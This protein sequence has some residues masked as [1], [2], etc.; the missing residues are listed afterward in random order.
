MAKNDLAAFYKNLRTLGIHLHGKTNTSME[1]NSMDDI[2][3]SLE[4]L[5]NETFEGDP[6]VVFHGLPM[7]AIR[8]ELNALPSEEEILEHVSQLKESAPGLDGLPYAAWYR[9]GPPAYTCVAGW[10]QTEENLQNK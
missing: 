1:P 7:R 8:P 10:S 2:I 3:K 4:T 5:G 6:N 9:G